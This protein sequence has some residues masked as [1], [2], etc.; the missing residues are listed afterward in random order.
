MTEYY[1]ATC[2]KK[3]ELLNKMRK[4]LHVCKYCGMNKLCSDDKEV[5]QFNRGKKK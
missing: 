2:A 1:C 3:N 5:K 4:T